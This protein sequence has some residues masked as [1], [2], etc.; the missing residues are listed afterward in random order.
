MFDDMDVYRINYSITTSFR[1]KVQYFYLNPFPLIHLEV[2]CIQII[3]QPHREKPKL[4]YVLYSMAIIKHQFPLFV[5]V[6]R[7]VES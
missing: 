1:M 2:E 6:T 3:N 4:N 7:C 5:T